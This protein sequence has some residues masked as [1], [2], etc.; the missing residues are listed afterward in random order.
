MSTPARRCFCSWRFWSECSHTTL[1]PK[2][3]GTKT[4]GGLEGLRFAIMSP[5]LGELLSLT[6]TP[7]TQRGGWGGVAWSTLPSCPSVCLAHTHLHDAHLDRGPETKSCM[8]T[9]PMSNI[10]F[11]PELPPAPLPFSHLPGASKPKSLRMDMSLTLTA[12]LPPPSRNAVPPGA[13]Q[14]TETPR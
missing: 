2:S 4:I 3:T 1:S 8:K 11:L 6:L 12:C 5:Y 14:G 7:C 13:G 10:V 9:A